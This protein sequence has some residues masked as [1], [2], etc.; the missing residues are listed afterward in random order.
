MSPLRSGKSGTERRCNS[1]RY[2][3]NPSNSYRGKCDQLSHLQ[4]Y[5]TKRVGTL[6][7]IIEK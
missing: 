5:R 3:Y 1:E 6:I 4:G 2:S 7:P